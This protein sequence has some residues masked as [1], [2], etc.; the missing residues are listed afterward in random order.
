MHLFAAE[1]VFKIEIFNTNGSTSSIT[2]HPCYLG[3][4][5]G[6]IRRCQVGGRWEGQP[7]PCRDLGVR[8]QSPSSAGSQPPPAQREEAGPVL[9][10]KREQCGDRDPDGSRPSPAALRLLPAPEA[11]PA[12]GTPAPVAALGPQPLRPRAA[13]GRRSRGRALGALRRRRSVGP[14]RSPGPG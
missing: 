11:R 5:W 14:A 4:R 7:R 3:T 1:N 2:P 6:R 13:S 8:R 10:R 12:P 9:D